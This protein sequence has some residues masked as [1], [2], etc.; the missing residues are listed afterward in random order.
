MPKCPNF[1]AGAVNLQGGQK[2]GNTR[3]QKLRRSGSGS[4]AGPGVAGQSGRMRALSGGRTL[5]APVEVALP[6]GL[7]L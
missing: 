6:D 5:N 1:V 2:A 7:A 4:G 3:P